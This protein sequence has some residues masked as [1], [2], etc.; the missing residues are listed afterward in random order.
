MPPFHGRSSKLQYFKQINCGI[1]EIFK[2]WFMIKAWS[3][4]RKKYSKAW[5]HISCARVIPFPSYDEK[6]ITWNTKNRK[7]VLKIRI[8]RCCQLSLHSQ[9]GNASNIAVVS[10]TLHYS[11]A[12]LTFIPTITSALDGLVTRRGWGDT[13]AFRSNTNTFDL[14]SETC[15]YELRY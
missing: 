2:R 10:I 13:D 8:D 3:F 7:N 11:N 5:Y 9:C 14:L 4:I 15:V 1:K 12:N 6:K